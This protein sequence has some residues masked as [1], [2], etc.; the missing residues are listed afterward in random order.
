MFT[1]TKLPHALYLAQEVRELD[2]IAIR[3]LGIPGSLLMDRA[4]FATFQ[5]MRRQWPGAR[6][7]RVLCGAGNNGGDGFIIARYAKRAGLDVKVFPVGDHSRLAGDALGAFESMSAAGVTPEPLRAGVLDDADVVVDALF[8]TGLDREISGPWSDAIAAMNRSPGT[9]LAVDIPSGLH[10]DTGRILGRATR[11]DL[12]V[13]FIG[14]KLGMFTGEGRDRCGRILFDDLGVPD[15]VHE[16]FQPSA[17]RMDYDSLRHLLAP[18]ARSTHKGDFGHVLII[19]GDSGFSGAVEMAG[20]AAARAGAGLVSIATRN[21]HA[22]VIGANRPELMCHGIETTRDLQGLLARATVLAIGPGLGQSPW[23]KAMLDTAIQTED[24]PL[25]IDADGLNLLAALPQ[26]GL[27]HRPG[28]HILTPHPGEAARLLDCPTA[29]IQ[30]DRFKTVRD[31]VSRF[32]GGAILK[33]SGTLV[34]DETGLSVVSEG[35]PGMASGGM[36]D[37][38]TGIIAGLVAQGIAIPDAARLAACL[39]GRAADMETENGERGMLA[40]DLMPRLRRLVNP[41]IDPVLDPMGV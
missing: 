20:E 31:L 12:T 30:N 28:G 36:G 29:M 25:I 11:A 32:G 38:L 9:T 8:G 19:G 39:H 34:F 27:H 6:F 37:V 3:D 24:L 33:G 15:R 16:R 2:R 26:H 5:A 40:R 1:A 4:G 13:T 7:I 41:E 10:A 14:L 21:A 23:A 22:D 18:R 17:R 35:N